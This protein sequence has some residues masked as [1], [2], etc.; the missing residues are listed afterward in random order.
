MVVT[1]VVILIIVIIIIITI[2]VVVIIVIMIIIIIIAVVFST[3]TVTALTSR[4]IICLVYGRSFLKD[5][6]V[7]FMGREEKMS[8]KTSSEG[9]IT[10]RKVKLG[11]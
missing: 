7:I 8:K 11:M 2:V 10:G 1:M 9:A 6:N 5:K 4:R 3:L